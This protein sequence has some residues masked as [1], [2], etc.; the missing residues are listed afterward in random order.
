M[1]TTFVLPMLLA[2]NMHAPTTAD[3]QA[4]SSSNLLKWAAEKNVILIAAPD[5][6]DDPNDERHMDGLPSWDQRNKHKPSSDPYNGSTSNNKWE[7]NRPYGD[8]PW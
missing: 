4:A 8:D 7:P 2:C 6:G 1:L 5:H 3:I